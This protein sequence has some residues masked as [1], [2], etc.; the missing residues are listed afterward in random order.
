[1]AQSLPAAEKDLMDS[2]RVKSL[3]HPVAQDILYAADFETVRDTELVPI[4]HVDLAHLLMLLTTGILR[5]EVVV[6]LISAILDLRDA[7][8]EPLRGRP[9]PRG[10]YMLY[11]SHLIERLGIETGGALQTARSRNDLSATIQKMRH[12]EALAD[13]AE[14]MLELEAALLTQAARHLD[15][16]FPVFTHYQ[17]AQVTTLAQYFLAI[18]ASVQRCHGVLEIQFDHLSASPLG[19]GAVT[20]TTFPIDTDMTASLLGFASGPENAIDAIASRDHVLRSVTECATLGATLSRLAHD[21]QLWTTQDYGLLEVDDSLVGISSMMPQKRNIYLTENVKGKLATAQGAAQAAAF[22]MHSTPFS[23]SIAVGTEATRHLWPALNDTR[24]ALRLITLLVAGV[25]PR[26]DRIVQRLA[27]GFCGATALAD[28]LV[29][30]A[31][32]SFRDAHHVVGGLIRDMQDAGMTGLEEGLR[33]FRPD[34]AHLLDR[35]DLNPTRILERQRY[36]GG[37]APDVQAGLLVQIRGEHRR[38]S[39]FLAER[40]NIWRRASARLTR[41]VQTAVAAVPLPL[42]PREGGPWNS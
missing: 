35:V 32:L 6:P 42:R 29:R 14:A 19:A 37:P 27:E 36:G 21:L 34:R 7:R 9:A 4:S 17:A 2:G 26:Q 41:Q 11:E 28:G 10:T 8:F 18:A 33:A 31:G 3:I 40:R 25:R 1:M 15:T 13:L 16:V 23:N 12:R 20:G 30:H 38:M 5:R 39:E 24:D 22:A